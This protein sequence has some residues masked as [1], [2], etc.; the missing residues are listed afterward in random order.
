MWYRVLHEENL[1]ILKSVVKDAILR[2]PRAG[3]QLENVEKHLAKI[4]MSVNVV[5]SLVSMCRTHDKVIV[6]AMAVKYGGKFVDSFLKG[7]LKH[8]DLMGQVV[9]S[10]A[11]ADDQNSNADEDLAEADDSDQPVSIASE[12]DKD[13][14]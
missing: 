8:K 13:M 12:E 14:E 7:N 1:A 6:H 11:Y 5:V 10:Q 2:K 4:Q 3:V 9:S